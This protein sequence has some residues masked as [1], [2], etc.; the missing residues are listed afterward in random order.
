MQDRII[1]TLAKYPEKNITQVARIMGLTTDQVARA[2]HDHLKI[3]M[4]K[5]RCSPMWNK[6]Q[7]NKHKV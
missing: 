5:F 3:K 7:Y 4:A 2:Q 1:N 6:K